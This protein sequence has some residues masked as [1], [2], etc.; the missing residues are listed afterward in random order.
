MPDLFQPGRI[1]FGPHEERRRIV[2]VESGVVHYESALSGTPGQA[3]EAEMDE[4]RLQSSRRIYYPA[5][6]AERRLLLHKDDDVARYILPEQGGGIVTEPRA[7][8]DEWR[9]TEAES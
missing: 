1:F 2:R 7:D 9:S 8:W 4:W 5:D 3:T 6:Y